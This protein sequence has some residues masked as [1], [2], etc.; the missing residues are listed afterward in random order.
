MSQNGTLPAAC[1]S[2]KDW[3]T[4]RDKTQEECAGAVG[5]TRQVW[6][7]WERGRRIPNRHFMPLVVNLTGG[8]VT[9]ASFYPPLSQVA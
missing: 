3:R 1:L 7:D 4:A 5:T 9:A 6:S 8:K 2:L